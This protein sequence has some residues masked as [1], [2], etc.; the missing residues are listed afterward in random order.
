MLFVGFSW[1]MHNLFNVLTLP[2]SMFQLSRTILG[3][4]RH[5]CASVNL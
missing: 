5:V 1:A 3:Y 2:N 4:G